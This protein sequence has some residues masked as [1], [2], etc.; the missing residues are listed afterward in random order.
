M[1]KVAEIKPISTK[2]INNLGGRTVKRVEILK[3]DGDRALLRI[4]TDTNKH[5]PYA[6]QWYVE[7]VDFTILGIEEQ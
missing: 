2:A 6:A 5:I 1:A 3:I 4:K 7:S